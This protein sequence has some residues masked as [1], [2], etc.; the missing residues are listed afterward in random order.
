MDRA[1]A[2]DRETLTAREVHVLRVYFCAQIRELCRRIPLRPRV[3][4]TACAYF[5]RFYL[6]TSFGAADPVL[7]A[8][9]CVY[10]AAKV[11][12]CTTQV[13]K[14]AQKAMQIEPRLFG[15]AP[16]ALLDHEY[17]VMQRVGFNLHVWHAHRSIP[18]LLESAGLRDDADT[19]E[20][21]WCAAN[22]AYVTDAVL[23]HHPHV[24]AL[25]AVLVGACVLKGKDL[26]WWFA[27]LAPPAAAEMKDVWAVAA[28]IL[29]TY[30]LW[31]QPDFA[32]SAHAILSKLR[33][34]RPVPAAN[35]P[36]TVV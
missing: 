13:K 25:A 2:R 28:M 18:L 24:I 4:A 33:I 14:V 1:N 22:D 32:K 10:L 7:V 5:R 26:R 9:T 16:E 29:D 11:E 20:A 17:A 15:Y 30:E 3:V 27:S 12:E 19:R 35:Q 36:I 6:D 8:P 34:S 23:T 21:V 31:S